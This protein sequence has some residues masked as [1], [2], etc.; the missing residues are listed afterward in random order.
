ME[1][2]ASSQEGRNKVDCMIIPI[3]ISA[4]EAEFA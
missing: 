4:Q 3:L 1:Q 2:K